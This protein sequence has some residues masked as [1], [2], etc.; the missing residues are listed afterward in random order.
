M[1]I[2]KI[3]GYK[4][5]NILIYNDKN[6]FYKKYAVTLLL[7]MESAQTASDVLNM[8]ISDIQ[9]GMHNLEY[10]VM[11]ANIIPAGYNV[12]DDTDI[13]GTFYAME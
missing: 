5:E 12:N 6:Q 9:D 7:D 2:Y 13:I 11:Q 8:V 4:T 1:L 10:D 3:F